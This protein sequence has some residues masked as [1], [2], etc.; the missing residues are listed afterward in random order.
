MP[1]IVGTPV[2]QTPVF[3]E[4]MKYMVFNPYWTVPFSIATKDKLAKLKT[5]P[6][7]LVEQGYEAQPAFQI[8]MP[9]IFTTRPITA[10]FRN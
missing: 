7:L 1:V 4:S 2:R 8:S 9:F 3:A 6:S 10:F 5:N